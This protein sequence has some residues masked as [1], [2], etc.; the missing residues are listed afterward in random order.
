MRDKNTSPQAE[1]NLLREHGDRVSNISNE[2]ER[3]WSE[4]RSSWREASAQT[5]GAR[6]AAA[7]RAGAC[8]PARRL[9]LQNISLNSALGLPTCAFG[10]PNGN[11]LDRRSVIPRVLRTGP[12]RAP[13]SPFY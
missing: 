12:F 8:E 11:V 2:A 13:R 3:A 1:Y 7:P 4:A 6:P 5:A 9:R 10:L